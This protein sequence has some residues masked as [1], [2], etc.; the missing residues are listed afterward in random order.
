MGVMGSK[1]K[2]EKKVFRVPYGEQT[3]KNGSI[4]SSNKKEEAI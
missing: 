2:I 1:S 4:P 3:A